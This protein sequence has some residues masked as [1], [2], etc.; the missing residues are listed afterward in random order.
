[1]PVYY[2]LFT[3]STIL[4]SNILYGDFAN[5][6]RG[7]VLLFASGCGLT[8][9]GVWLLTSKRP[10]RASASIPPHDERRAPMLAK[11]SPPGLLGEAGPEG[12]GAGGAAGVQYADEPSFNRLFVPP[13]PR[14]HDRCGVSASLSGPPTGLQIMMDDEYLEHGVPLGLL[15]SPL[16]LSGDVLRRTFSSRLSS[17]NDRAASGGGHSGGPSHRRTTSV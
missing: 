12:G 4:G 11:E 16:A 6:D 5:E 17:F 9:G 3:L 7:V 2:V 14:A 8:F 15:N 1:M 10:S 13:P